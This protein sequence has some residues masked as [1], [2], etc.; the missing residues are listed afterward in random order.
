MSKTRRTIKNPAKTSRVTV[1]QARSAAK[2]AKDGRTVES[3]QPAAAS[4]G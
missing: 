4:R 2:A 3:R 1:N